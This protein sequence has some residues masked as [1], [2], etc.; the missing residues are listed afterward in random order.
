MYDAMVYDKEKITLVIPAKNEKANLM[1]LLPTIPNFIDEIIVVDSNSNDGTREMLGM[2]SNVVY[3]LQTN[4]G[5]GAALQIG[6]EAAK[7]EYIICM[8]ADGSM[9][10]NEIPHLLELLVEEKNHL[11]KGSRYLSGGGVR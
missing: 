2:Y 4:R 8:D 10:T 6:I 9:H 5:K 7:F 11:V 1:R 3:I